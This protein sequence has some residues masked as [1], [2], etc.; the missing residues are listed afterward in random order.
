MVYGHKF[1]EWV[2]G[3]DTV[4]PCMQCCYSIAA[5]TTVNNIGKDEILRQPA[6]LG[7][8]LTKGK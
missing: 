6:A 4:Q 5:T 3:R 1:V 7:L 8:E 2:K